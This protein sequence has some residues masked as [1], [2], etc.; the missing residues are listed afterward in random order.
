MAVIDH[1]VPRLDVPMNAVV[2]LVYMGYTLQQLLGNWNSF[3]LKLFLDVLL[4][5]LAFGF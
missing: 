4:V 3:N 5:D 2:F 1:D